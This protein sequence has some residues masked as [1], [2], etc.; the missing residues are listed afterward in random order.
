MAYWHDY[1]EC[2]GGAWDCDATKP[3]GVE[4]P[5]VCPDE[6]HK[7]YVACVSDCHKTCTDP[8]GEN[9]SDCDPLVSTTRFTPFLLNVNF[10][11]VLKWFMACA[12]KFEIAYF[13][14]WVSTK[15]NWFCLWL[16]IYRWKPVVW[17]HWS[18]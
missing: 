7:E 3:P 8:E 16:N 9:D 2:D 4:V 1:S 13:I 17:K 6:Q 14:P 5:D 18:F 10:D 15:F 11:L 12:K